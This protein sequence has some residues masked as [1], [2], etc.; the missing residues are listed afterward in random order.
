LALSVAEVDAMAAAA[1]QAGVVLAEAFMYRHHPQTLKVKE[2]VTG[3]A[4]GRVQL[5]RG[6]FTFTLR[7]PE[8]PR[9]V[10]EM[11]GGSVWDIGCYPVSYARFI[12]G[13]EPVEA[14]GWQVLSASGVDET[15]IGQLRFPGGVLAQFDC[16]FAS[17]AR[18]HLE[19]VGTEGTLRIKV[20]FHPK[21]DERVRLARGDE[22]QTLAMPGQDLYAGEVEDM[23]DAIGLGQAPRVT[24]AE[25]RGNVAALAALLQSARTGRV[26]TLE[27]G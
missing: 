1:R 12:L 15:F 19:V 13:A 10:P 2:L 16:G 27:A 5:V 21:H 20:P 9:W 8:D 11:G 23:A 6:S 14:F 4:V 3:G 22:V 17:P 24:L 25:S 26:V 18:T 7:R